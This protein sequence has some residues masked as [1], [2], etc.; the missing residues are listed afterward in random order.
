LTVMSDPRHRLR[1]PAAVRLPLG[2]DPGVLLPALRAAIPTEENVAPTAEAVRQGHDGLAAL[3]V[4]TVR[5][6]AVATGHAPEPFL[7]KTSAL[8]RVSRP[9]GRPPASTLTWVRQ[10]TCIEWALQDLNLFTSLLQV[11][12]AQAL[13]A[14]TPCPRPACVHGRV[15]PCGTRI[16]RSGATWRHF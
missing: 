4:E 11:L 3:L 8:S 13:L 9:R 1:Q 16:I 12:L 10:R 7:R 5:G 15:A 6:D 2:Q 14:T